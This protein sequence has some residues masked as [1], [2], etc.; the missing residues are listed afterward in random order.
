[1]GV[2]DKTCR[3]ATTDK[4]LNIRSENESSGKY[5]NQFHGRK[6]SNRTEPTPVPQGLQTFATA[7]LNIPCLSNI[8][9]AVA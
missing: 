1:M 3:F 9:Q 7:F 4:T 6:D 8:P 5:S 2:L